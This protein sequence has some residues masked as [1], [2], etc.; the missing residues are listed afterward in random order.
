[1]TD[2]EIVTILNHNPGLCKIFLGSGKKN[3]RKNY[4]FRVIWL[5]QAKEVVAFHK[6]TGISLY[7]TLLGPAGDIM[8]PLSRICV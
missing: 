8:L 4:P 3:Q 1:M 7:L 6:M 2:V 5:I